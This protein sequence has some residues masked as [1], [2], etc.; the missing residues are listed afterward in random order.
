MH[1]H[2]GAHALHLHEN[3]K[4]IKEKRPPAKKPFPALRIGVRYQEKACFVS[5]ETPFL[6]G[7]AP[8]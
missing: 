2:S 3:Q 1:D 7:L 4:T 6:E 8:K 5:L